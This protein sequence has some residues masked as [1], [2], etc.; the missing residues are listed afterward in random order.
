M[1]IFLAVSVPPVASGV[2][3]EAQRRLKEFLPGA[4]WT[5]I[6]AF[7]ITLRFLGEVQPGRLAEVDSAARKAA[8]NERPFRVE[9]KGLGVFPYSRGPRIVW[10]GISEGKSALVRLAE[11]LETNL[12]A[13]GFPRERRPYRPHVTL[14]RFKDGS[15]GAVKSDASASFGGFEANELNVMQSELR[16]Q[17]PLYTVLRRCPFKEHECPRA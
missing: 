13:L 15:P 12:T 17:G 2:L 5:G 6:D 16:P 4:R 7:H 1:R 9:L 10:A 8:E 11:N 3:S 14:G